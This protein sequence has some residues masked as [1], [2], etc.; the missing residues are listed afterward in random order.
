MSLRGT[1]PLSA[2]ALEVAARAETPMTAPAR[3]AAVREIACMSYS[4]FM[5]G[6]R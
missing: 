4:W 6:D 5:V 1:P 2:D 3:K